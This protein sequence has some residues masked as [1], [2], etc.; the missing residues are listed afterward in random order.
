[1]KN[2]VGKW[3]RENDGGTVF[4]SSRKTWYVSLGIKQIYFS[5]PEQF[6]R[7]LLGHNDHRILVHYF[8]MRFKKNNIKT[9]SLST[10]LIYMSC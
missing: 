2:L 8:L 1:M 5:L 9:S 4:V 6:G 7:L 3:V 10:M